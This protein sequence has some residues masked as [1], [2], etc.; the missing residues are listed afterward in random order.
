MYVETVLEFAVRT[1]E[2]FFVVMPQIATLLPQ[3][4]PNKQKMLVAMERSIGK[5]TL[6]RLR[7]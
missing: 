7:A 3:G 6:C 2:R 5:L 4:G 1:P